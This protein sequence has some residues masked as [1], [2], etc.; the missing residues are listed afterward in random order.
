M[1]NAESITTLP[2]GYPFI[3]IP[4]DFKVCDRGLLHFDIDIP[5]GK[6]MVSGGYGY[7]TCTS[8]PNVLISAGL[9]LPDWLPGF[10]GNNKNTQLV[11]FTNAGPMCIFGN[12]RGARKSIPY[13]ALQVIGNGKTSIRIAFP[14]TE[15]QRTIIAEKKLR[16]EQALLIEMRRE[17]RAA[18]DA[19]RYRQSIDHA[20]D[21]VVSFLTMQLER[22]SDS[23]AEALLG[24]SRYRITNEAQAEIRRHLMAAVQVAQKREAYRLANRALSLV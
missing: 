2:D 11:V 20:R 14:M 15:Q 17:A 1:A 18:C 4:D 9:L 7:L 21:Q 24:E 3:A 6:I 13:P 22:C 12:Q 10:A 19:E 16:D 5:L 8:S 23:L